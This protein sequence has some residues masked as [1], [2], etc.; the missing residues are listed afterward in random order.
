M[1]ATANSLFVA[2]TLKSLKNSSPSPRSL[3]PSI[4]FGASCP[5]PPADDNCFF[6]RVPLAH[7]RP[8]QM[9]VGMRAVEAKRRKVER[10]AGRK[11]KMRRFLEK[12]PIPV[13]AGPDDEFYMI[14]HHH[15]CLALWHN[16][17]EEVLIRVVSDLS[18]MSKR[19]FLNSMAALGWLHAYDARGQKIC[20]TKLP[21]SIDKLR[22]DPYRDL[23]WSVREDGGFR[24]TGIPFIEFAWANFFRLNIPERLVK[25]DFARAHRE[26]LRLARSDA[27]RN[28][29]GYVAKS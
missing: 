25:N 12:R 22:S 5:P 1:K 6:D 4:I 21:P 9:A 14:D 7:L 16:D 13:I 24:K 26:A 11:R 19:E 2:M 8:T 17:V 18:D 28:I 10:H 20:P 27:A 15:L 3:P 23:A 29:P